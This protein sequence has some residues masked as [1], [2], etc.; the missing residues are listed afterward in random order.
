MTKKADSFNKDVKTGMAW[1]VLERGGVQICKFLASIALARLL[2]PSD[3]GV[4]GLSVLFTGV[5][6]SISNFSFGMAIIQRDDVRPDHFATLF[7]TQLVINSTVCA[8]LILLSPSVGAYFDNPLVGSVL[9]VSALNFLIRVLGGCPSAML[10]RGR[11]FKALSLSNVIDAFVDVCVSVALALMGFGVWSLVFGALSGALV[12]NVYLVHASR[13]RPSLRVTKQ[14]F[15]ELFGFGMGVSVSELLTDAADRAANFVIGKV[16]GTAALGYFEKGQSLMNRPVRDLGRRAQRVLFPVFARIRHEP[17][18]FRAAVRRTI[19]TVSLIGYPLFVSLIVL[20]PQIIHVLFGS[21]WEPAVLPFQ[22]LC[23]TGLPRLIMQVMVMVTFVTGSSR[24]EMKRRTV[25]ALLTLAGSIV[26]VQWG[27]AGVATAVTA[28]S[29][30]G[31]ASAIWQVHHLG[32]LKSFT[33]VLKPQSVPLA[34]AVLMV[35]AE[36]ASQA[37]TQSLG[38]NEF[39]V[40]TVSVAIGSAAYL[41]TIAVMRDEDLTRLVGELVGDIAPVTTRVPMLGTLARRFR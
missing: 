4:L 33:D 15:K 26:G 5:S 28:V 9:A 27:L 20:A 37:W 35:V 25:M 38:L 24:Y 3:F 10:R 19:M 7:V 11:G 32:L 8:G 36:R 2:S 41:A 18:R 12:S 31:L 21:Q 17:G 34:G 39:V 22:I 23:I 6:G 14:A 1:G 40:L 16:L 30:L 13:W 29:M